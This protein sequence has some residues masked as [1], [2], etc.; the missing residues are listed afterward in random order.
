[1]QKPP[2]WADLIGTAWIIVV[3]IVYF[4]G[5]FWPEQIGTLTARFEAIYA[6]MVLLTAA[7]LTL[8]YLTRDRS[9]DR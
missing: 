1:M 9:P 2:I 4:G 7:V 8:R 6:F 3:A 5:Y